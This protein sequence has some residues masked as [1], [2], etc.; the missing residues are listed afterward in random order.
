LLQGIAQREEENLRGIAD[1]ILLVLDRLKFD[2]KE[3]AV[4]QFAIVGP[5]GAHLVFSGTKA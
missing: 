5:S 1:G 2:L 4:L 3:A